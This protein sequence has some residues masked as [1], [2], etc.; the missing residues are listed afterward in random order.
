MAALDEL[1]AAASVVA[2]DIDSNALDD[3]ALEEGHESSVSGQAIVPFAQLVGAEKENEG[4]PPVCQK[5]QAVHP[6]VSITPRMLR[7]APPDRSVTFWIH[8]Q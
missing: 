2:M 6:K 1:A 5:P 3:P 8:P 7:F 4:V